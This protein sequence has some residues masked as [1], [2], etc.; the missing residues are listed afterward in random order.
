MFGM[1]T[2]AEGAVFLVKFKPSK[3]PPLAAVVGRKHAL[4]F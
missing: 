3:L 2:V 1:L 4:S